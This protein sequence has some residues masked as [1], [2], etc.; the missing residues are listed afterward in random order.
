MA[1]VITNSPWTECQPNAKLLPARGMDY[2]ARWTR[3]KNEP[4][5]VALSF[6]SYVFYNCRVLFI[7]GKINFKKVYSL[8]SAEVFH[9]CD[10]SIFL[11]CIWVFFFVFVLNKVVR[12]PAYIIFLILELDGIAERVMTSASGGTEFCFLSALH[13]YFGF[14][15][16][17]IESLGNKVRCFP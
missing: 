15:S 12:W 17:N 16:R 3:E 5:I 13:V 11:N 10:T 7:I 2:R 6:D 4:R 9:V 1:R 8:F 14:A